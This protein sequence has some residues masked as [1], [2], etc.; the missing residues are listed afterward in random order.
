M[1]FILKLFLVLIFPNLLF[2]QQKEEIT[3]TSLTRFSKSELKNY[4]ACVF[5]FISPECPLCQAYS[6]SINNLYCEYHPKGIELLG[7]VSGT[8]FSV[9]EI[10][11]Y[12]NKYNLQIP[13]YLDKNKYLS[14]KYNASITPQAILINRTDTILYSGRIDNW[15]YALGKKRKNITEHSLKEAI[16]DVINSRTVRIPITKAIGCFIE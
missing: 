2:S 4:K 12:K 6:L 7:I 14:Q 8:L 5:I 9:R 13:L 1:N 15:S 3:D 11:N 10:E 16:E